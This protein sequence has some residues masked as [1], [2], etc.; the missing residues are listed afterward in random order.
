MFDAIAGRYDLM[1]RV[2]T[3]GQ[4]QKWRRFVVKMAGDPGDGYT[5]DLATGTGDIGALMTDTYPRSK[6]GGWGFFPQYAARGEKT[7]CRQAD[8]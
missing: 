5:L 2:M 4:D 3:L 1:N 8:R 7:F 6:S